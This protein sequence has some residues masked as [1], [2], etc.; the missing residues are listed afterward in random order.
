MHLRRQPFIQGEA[1]VDIRGRASGSARFEFKNS[2]DCRRPHSNYLD[3]FLELHALEL[4]GRLS[5]ITRTRI[6]WTSFSNYTHSNYLDVFLELHALELLGRLSR[7]TRTG[8]TWTSFLGLEEP[9]LKLLR[10]AELQRTKPSPISN[11]R[12][13]KSAI[14]ISRKINHNIN[15]L[16][17]LGVGIR[18][19]YYYYYYYIHIYNIIGRA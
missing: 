8:I 5:R 16:L 13:S 1:H 2:W 10:L 12:R 15:S 19:I 17:L 4:L 11:C 3:V 6:T 14:I 7:I 9:S 18:I